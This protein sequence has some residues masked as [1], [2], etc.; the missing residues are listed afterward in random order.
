MYVRGLTITHN[1]EIN[2]SKYFV[3]ELRNWEGV[4][5]CHVTFLPGQSQE[6]LPNPPAAH[7]HSVGELSNFPV[8]PSGSCG[9]IGGAAGRHPAS[10]N[11]RDLSPL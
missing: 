6:N 8:S 2:S 11:E 4:V 1:N 10:Q 9:P 3:L 5:V 7:L